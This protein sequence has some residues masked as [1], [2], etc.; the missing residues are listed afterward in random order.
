METLNCLLKRA[1]E[2]GYISRVKVK[3]RGDEGVKVSHLL[4]AND[5]HVF[6]EASQDQMV[7]LCWLHCTW[8]EAC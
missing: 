1:M 2:G 7:H 8:F 6:C 5:T 4:F 3:R